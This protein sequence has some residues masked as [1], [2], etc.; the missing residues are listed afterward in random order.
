MD[1][2]KVRVT[3]DTRQAKSELAGFV[4]SAASTAG[5]VSGSVR[6]AITRGLGV[7]GFGG[8]VGAGIAAIRGPTE[9]GA[10]GA[11]SEALGGIGRQVADF[12]LGDLNEEARA[13]KSAREEAIQAFGAIA[14]ARNAIPPGLGSY[15]DSIKSIR[16]QEEKGRKLIEMDDDFRGPGIGAIIDRVLAGFKQLFDEAV[17]R[18]LGSAGST[19]LKGL[20]PLHFPGMK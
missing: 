17:D 15:F 13:S 20:N 11:I 1:D 18:L 10:S 12:F 5:R 6:S 4:R 7:V 8:A 14:G 19:L 16:L 3:L 9:S 2:T